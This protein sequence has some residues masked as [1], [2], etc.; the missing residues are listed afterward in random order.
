M[1]LS[2]LAAAVFVGGVAYGG[3][4]VWNA[5][6]RREVAARTAEL[7]ASAAE[8]ERLIAD[9]ES[10]NAELERFSYT[11]SHDLKS[12]LVT[13]GTF[14]GLLEKSLLAGELG[15]VQEDVGR[16]QRAADRMRRLLEELL[17]LS[18][19]G[20]V[21]NAREDVPLKALALEAAD[22]VR[23]RLTQGSIEIH[24]ADDLPTVR[25][26]RVRLLEVML[27]LIDN[28]AK[29]ASAGTPPRIEVGVAP[30]RP[31]PSFYVRDNGIGI[32]PQHQDKVFG[33]FDKLDPQSDGTGIG[34]ALVRRIV[35]AHGGRIS[36]ESPGPGL[37]ATFHVSLGA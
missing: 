36:V 23:G 33:L 22:L 18:R 34:L 26:D 37:G 11:V 29:F 8:K 13:I 10:K 19:V 2:A 20:L 4:R 16:I 28:A 12:P 27:N 32:D 14:A 5:S 7:V 35:E 9:L 30:D 15:A 6:L 1:A 25:G 17:A 21:V 3:A 31:A 24:V